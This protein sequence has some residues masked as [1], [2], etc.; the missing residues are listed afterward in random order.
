MEATLALGLE[1]LCWRREKQGSCEMQWCWGGGGQ[2][3]PYG[4]TPLRHLVFCNH[5]VWQPGGRNQWCCLH[6][7]ASQ[8]LTTLTFIKRIK[9]D[10]QNPEVGGWLSLL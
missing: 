4:G 10:K 5:T 2:E 7:G 6:I 1:R 8:L 9:E 3:E